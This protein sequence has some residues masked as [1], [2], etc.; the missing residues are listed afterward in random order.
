MG[1]TSAR[2]VCKAMRRAGTWH[3]LMRQIQQN[4]TVHYPRITSTAASRPT[5]E[6][7]VLTGWKLATQKENVVCFWRHEPRVRFATPERRRKA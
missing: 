7:R 1:I 6:T 2:K 5:S 3:C 4:T